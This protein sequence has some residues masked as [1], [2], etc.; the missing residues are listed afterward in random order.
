LPAFPAQAQRFEY[1]AQ[2]YAQDGNIWKAWPPRSKPAP[3]RTSPH[4]GRKELPL[5]HLPLIVR[6]GPAGQLAG[7]MNWLTWRAEVGLAGEAPGYRFL[8]RADWGDQLLKYIRENSAFYTLTL[9]IF[10]DIL[11]LNDNHV[12]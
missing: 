12:Q 4:P 6:A 8:L 2:K 11:L 9:T 7:K 3:K 1:D 5:L 10:P